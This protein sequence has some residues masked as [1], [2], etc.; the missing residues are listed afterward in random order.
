MEL[1]GRGRRRE[2]KEGAKG[3]KKVSKKSKKHLTKG[4]RDDI[5]RNAHRER[6]AQ[7][8]LKIKQY[9]KA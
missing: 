6:G 5:I 7:R 2:R 9:R 1:S 4:L 3:S 8:T